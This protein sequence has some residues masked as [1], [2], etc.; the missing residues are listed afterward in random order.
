M[1]KVLYSGLS[2]S[3]GNGKIPVKLYSRVASQEPLTKATVMR[4]FATESHRE[5][6]DW[7][8]RPTRVHWEGDPTGTTIYDVFAIP[9]CEE[10]A[11]RYRD[12]QSTEEHLGQI[13]REAQFDFLV[14][15]T[16]PSMTLAASNRILRLPLIA[17]CDKNGIVLVFDPNFEV[18]LQPLF[19]NWFAGSFNKHDGSADIYC[20]APTGAV[21]AFLDP[22]TQ[23]TIL[24]FFNH[25]GKMVVTWHQTYDGN[26]HVHADPQTLPEE[27]IRHL[28]RTKPQLKEIE[29]SLREC[30]QAI[31][32]VLLSA[33]Q[34]LA[35]RS[36]R[37][38]PMFNPN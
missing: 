2:H 12:R 11:P 37:P 19:T 1:A 10:D 4:L 30:Q 38:D 14:E 22:Y 31:S 32:R 28:I 15:K 13:V 20:Y 29:D 8:V 24:R 36:S 25:E 26:Q 16:H 3:C 33:V 34:D 17:A 21:D 9:V 18:L 23:K 5:S 6:A 27:A 35:R 7:V